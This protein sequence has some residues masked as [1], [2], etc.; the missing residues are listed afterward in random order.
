MIKKSRENIGLKR[1]ENSVSFVDTTRDAEYTFQ[2]YDFPDR[3]YLGKNSFKILANSDNLAQGASILI[4]IEDDL[5]N[6]IYYEIT[7]IINRDRSR[8]IVVYIYDDTP[9][10]YVNVYIASTL[11][12]NPLTGQLLNQDITN[13]LWKKRV[14]VSTTKTAAESIIFSTPPKIIFQERSEKR[15]IYNTTSSRF[16]NDKNRGSGQ[17]TLVSKNSIYDLSTNRQVKDIDLAAE[18]IQPVPTIN[19]IVGT[20][21]G[22]TRIPKFAPRSLIQTNSDFPLTASMVGGQ[23]LVRNIDISSSAPAEI[24]NS[25]GSPDYSASILRV[26]NRTTAEVYPPFNYNT[27]YVLDG[28]LRTLSVNK[29]VGETNFTASWLT[30]LE[31]TIGDTSQSFLQMEIQGLQPDVGDVRYVRVQYKELGGYGNFKDLGKYRI[32][33][34]DNLLVDTGSVEVTK[35]GLQEKKIGYTNTP[36]IYYTSSGV[37]V[38]G[39][40]LIG[41]DRLIQNAFEVTHSLITD[42]AS[43]ARI[44]LRD[45]YYPTVVK[46]SQYEFQFLCSNSTTSSFVRPQLDIYLSGSKILIEDVDLLKNQLPLLSNIDGTYIGTVITDN[47]SYKEFKQ[48]FQAL[49]TKEVTPIF[50][51]RSGQWNIGQVE[52]RTSQERGFTPNHSRVFIPLPEQSFGQEVLFQVQY[53]NELDEPSELVQEFSGL[54]FK[55]SQTGD[56][57]ETISKDNVTFDENSKSNPIQWNRLALVNSGSFEISYSSSAGE[58]SVVNYITQFT[59]SANNIGLPGQVIYPIL[60]DNIDNTKYSG[61]E[62]VSGIIY[63]IETVIF[64]KTGSFGSLINSAV[65]ASTIQGRVIVNDSD[66]IGR[67]HTI[68]ASGSE[69]RLIGTFG[70]GPD[71]TDIGGGDNLDSWYRVTLVDPADTGDLNVRHTITTT[72]SFNWD[73]YLTSYCRVVKFDQRF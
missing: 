34:F 45:V 36:L 59:W 72:S 27:T 48:E 61:S 73:F 40:S 39:L 22:P 64:G 2:V 47:E 5:G 30:V 11:K 44:Q 70:P 57:F 17:I 52:L 50:V 63:T 8:T 42:S 35:N 29:F 9:I 55:G 7:N 15:R 37:G 28:E 12:R 49:E 32:N 68:I 1:Y 24:A 67:Y 10:G 41:S 69:E 21:E 20:Y 23:I 4:D 53:L 3:F 19:G 43:Y 38:T 51:I 56:T 71:G 14:L 33:E 58:S 18:T 25:L 54:Y 66:N 46:N 65:W 6:P 31:P 62:E 13:V 60:K 26:I 16:V